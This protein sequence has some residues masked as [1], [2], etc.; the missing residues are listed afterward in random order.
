MTETG[1]GNVVVITGTDTG[2]G[3]TMV[4]AGLARALRDRGAKV[5][6]VKPVESGTSPRPKPCED[7]AILAAASGQAQPRWAL[8]RLR[9]PLAPPVAADA[10][11]V[12]LDMDAWC[13]EIRSYAESADLVLVEGAG[14]VLSPLTWTETSRELAARLG[15]PAVLV[16]VDRLGTLNHILMALEV[17]EHAGVPTA[18]IVL[19]APTAAD[20]STGKNADALS[21]FSGF[22][23]IAVFPRVSSFEA[24]AARLGGV[25]EWLVT[26]GDSKSSG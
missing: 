18:A 15:G 14:G 9:A 6:A 7:G 19:N 5:C 3:K 21:E 17:L 25:A 13:A 26:Q 8:T 23:R 2:V 4:A 10:E 16:A 11:G 12:Q 1:M 24:A 22:E 20:A